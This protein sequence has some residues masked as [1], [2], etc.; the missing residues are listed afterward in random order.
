MS[1]RQSLMD[2]PQ[3]A[4][5]FLIS[6]T[7]HIERQV[8]EKK[9]P[10]MTYAEDV[11]VDN[12]APEWIKSVTYFSTDKVG[13]MAL[14]HGRANDIPLVDINR[15]KHETEVVMAGIGYD[16]SLEEL[17]QAFML[18][19]SLT[20]DKAAAARRAYEEYV[21]GMAYTGDAQ[22]GFTGLFNNASIAQSSAPNGASGTATWATKTADEILKDINGAITGIW[23][24]SNTIEMADTI[25]IPVAH[26]ALIASKRLDATMTM[27]VLEYVLKSNIYT[28]ITGKPLR[29]RA[30]LELAGAGS[31]GTHRLMAYRRDPEV[32]KLHIPMPLKFLAAQGPLGFLYMVPGMCRLGGVDVRRPGSCRYLDGI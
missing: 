18:G 31:G 13:K 6:Q 15:E 25:L 11:P 12:S 7:T 30:R 27:T 29:I 23:T 8:W 22:V 19:I 2:A 14:I 21:Q 20:V 32:M 26:Y 3:A 9:Y 4:L 5:G 17:N 28:A 24:G 10:E 16:Y 1:R